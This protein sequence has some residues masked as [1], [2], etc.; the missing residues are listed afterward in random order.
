PSATAA[1][2]SS[3]D[4][5]STR[6]P[7]TP[8]PGSSTTRPRSSAALARAQQRRT[9]VRRSAQ[10]IKIGRNIFAV[11]TAHA[12][13]RHCRMLLNSMWIHNPVLQVV[14]RVRHLPG[15]VDPQGK[16]GERRTYLAGG[17]LNPGDGV[18]GAASVIPDLLLAAMRVSSSGADG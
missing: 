1:L 9:I 11:F 3:C 17:L 15:N 10:R 2:S 7:G 6:Q 4:C 14:R 18:A 12:H 8:A 16:V 13:F 5:M